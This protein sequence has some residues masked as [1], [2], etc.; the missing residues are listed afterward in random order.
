M[1][2]GITIIYD[3][4]C[5]FCSSY[6]SMVR[7]R[8]TVGEVELIDA[9]SDAPSVLAALSA[10]YDLDQGMLVT[11]DGKQFF[12]QDAVHLLAT[13]SAPSGGFNTLQRLVFASPRRAALLY[14][15]LA[16]GRRLFLRLVGR[17]TIAEK[18]KSGA[19]TE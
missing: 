14:P 13:L 19:R 4:E 9:R 16:G 8:E 6:V 15:V 18:R 11:W 10:G 17:Q 5:P 12:G 7:L 3:G 1:H 2:D